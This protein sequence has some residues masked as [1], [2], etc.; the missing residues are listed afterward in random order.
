MLSQS[1]LERNSILAS[2]VG[3]LNNTGVQHLSL[4]E[5]PLQLQPESGEW[6]HLNRNEMV[7]NQ[8]PTSSKEGLPNMANINA[9][10]YRSLYFYGDR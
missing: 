5:E 1:S 8:F 6:T 3:G 2:S 7:E 4:N 9:S 10:E